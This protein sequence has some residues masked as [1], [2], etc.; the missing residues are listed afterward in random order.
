MCYPL[1][2]HVKRI[3]PTEEED[4]FKERPAYSVVVRTWDRVVF[5]CSHY[6][7]QETTNALVHFIR[8]E[9]LEHGRGLYMPA[10]EFKEAFNRHCDENHFY[11]HRWVKD[12]YHGPFE[13]NQLCIRTLRRKYPRDRADALSVHCQFILG[14]DLRTDAVVEVDPFDPE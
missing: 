6:D 14:C 9:K 7:L 1:L 4:G 8:S 5:V 13:M 3:N 11:K 10:K 12:Y 2:G